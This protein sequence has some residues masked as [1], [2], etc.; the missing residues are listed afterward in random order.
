ME[1]ELV[2]EKTSKEQ[3]DEAIR[4]GG[5]TIVPVHCFLQGKM[6]SDPKEVF[7]LGIGGDRNLYISF[8]NG[9]RRVLIS[10]DKILNEAHRLA[11]EE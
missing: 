1:I 5:G 2:K 6:P 4:T 3:Q 7:S 11:T 8:R 9:K 10:F